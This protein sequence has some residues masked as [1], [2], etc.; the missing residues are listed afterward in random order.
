MGSE[1]YDPMS[2]KGHPRRSSSSP[3][4]HRQ[5]EPDGYHL[6][7]STNTRRRGGGGSGSHSGFF[8]GGRKK[9]LSVKYC[10]PTMLL[11]SVLS[12]LFMLNA[13]SNEMKGEALVRPQQQYQQHDED[14]KGH[15]G[16]WIPHPKSSEWSASASSSS[17]SQ[18]HSQSQQ[19][20]QQQHDLRQRRRLNQ[21]DDTS[22]NGTGTAR[23]SATATTGTTVTAATI[24][25]SPTTSTS[26]SQSAAVVQ[27]SVLTTIT[28]AA[29]AANKS[30]YGD[31]MTP[32]ELREIRQQIR[33]KEREKHNNNNNNNDNNNGQQQINPSH[34]STASD[35]NWTHPP[36]DWQAVSLPKRNQRPQTFPK[37]SVGQTRPMDPLGGEFD[38]WSLRPLSSNL[39]IDATNLGVLLDGGR[40]YYPVD[41]VKRMIHV[42][43]MMKYNLLHFRLTDDQVF[44]VQLKSRPLLAYPSRLNGNT[45]VYQPDELRDIVQFAKQRNVT[46]I[47]EINVPGHAGAWGG[48]PE[49]L[50]QCPNFICQKGYSVPLNVSNPLLRPVLKDVLAEV[51]DIFD[52]PP[53]LHLGGDEVDMSLPCMNEIG[54]PKFDYNIFEAMLR[55]ILLEVGYDDSRVIRWEMMTF[56]EGLDRAGNITHFWFTQPGHK[57][58]GV[59]MR[60]DR[61]YNDFKHPVFNSQ[62]LYFDVNDHDSAHDIYVHAQQNTHLKHVDSPNLGI[63]AGTFELGV[64]HWVD[65]NVI[66]KLLAVAI[67]ASHVDIHSEHEL[68]TFYKH[69]CRH[70]GFRD[71]LCLL[72]A[73]GP[74]DFNQ[75]RQGLKNGPHEHVTWNKWIKDIC[76]R[77][78]TD[79]D[80]RVYNPS[81]HPHNYK[82]GLVQ[83]GQNAFW[84][85][86]DDVA[87]RVLMDPEKASETKSK[88]SSFDGLRRHVEHTGIIIGLSTDPHRDHRI[89]EIFTKTMRRMGFNLA[90]LRLIDDLG[91][92]YRSKVFPELQFTHIGGSL[93]EADGL[94]NLRSTASAHGI[95][96]MPEVSLITNSAGMYNSNFNV[97]CP[98]YTC[99]RGSD[100]KHPWNI[101]LPMDINDSNF[102]PIAHAIIYEVLGFSSSPF[103]HL[104]GDERRTVAPC[105]DEALHEVPNFEGFEKKLDRLLQMSNVT[106]DR[107]I[108]WENEEQTHYGGRLGDVT[109]CR[110]GDDACPDRYGFSKIPWMAT[111]D[112][113]HGGAWEIFEKTRRMVTMQNR[114]LGIVAELGGLSVDYFKQNQ[115]DLRLLAF[116]LAT[117]DSSAAPDDTSL[118]IK[119]RDD[120]H[121]QFPRLC[122]E[123]LHLEESVCSSFANQ[124]QSSESLYNEQK[125]RSSWQE[126]L[127][128]ITCQMFTRLEKVK[129]FRNDTIPTAVS[130][131]K[132]TAKSSNATNH[133]STANK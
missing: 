133:M 80:K 19:Q 26:S 49:L 44:N 117:I 78:T 35:G 75:F 23:A 60:W 16:G 6:S 67:G 92:S 4:H 100:T 36:I 33:R 10:L 15:G 14:N 11:I 106:T 124:T 46:V 107:V 64:D 27:S 88:P 1:E 9:L 125:Q 22:L 38:V 45:K 90:Q 55:E 81:G 131:N 103:L 41:W 120:F 24:T 3:Y 132:N 71:D 126:S 82:N 31:S 97:E 32:E 54:A 72:Y 50:V 40:H 70:I 2:K 18:Q 127:K 30:A 59:G 111:V 28:P 94:T 73:D 17:S 99:H 34:N 122:V 116:N 47:P 21:S 113:R 86:L 109:Q 61:Y 93:P 65:R 87:N 66:G 77:F 20:H 51:I 119:S 91:F 128:Q 105:F 115:V 104:G 25:T 108:R 29:T 42:I 39:T 7:S 118:T 74:M 114:P 13:F 63:I 101:G 84:N 129:V 76:E 79:T 121:A 5:Q 95:A 98:E 57:G 83:S 58:T 102:V 96:I 62:G 85:S 52:N 56:M 37:D 8:S 68:Y 112:I 43:S 123:V 69:Q 89:A 48:M 110:P 53:L 12:M 130:L